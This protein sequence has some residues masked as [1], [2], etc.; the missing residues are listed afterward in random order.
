MEQQHTETA[1]EFNPRFVAFAQARGQTPDEA[2]AAAK[3]RRTGGMMDFILWINAKWCEWRRLNKRERFSR[4]S[5][6]DHA[7]FDAWLNAS[8]TQPMQV[9]A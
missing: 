3:A 7:A 9:F 5:P 6:D 4:L 2:L 1:K 8:I